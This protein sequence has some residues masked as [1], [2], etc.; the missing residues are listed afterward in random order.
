MGQLSAGIIAQARHADPRP[1]FNLWASLAGIN[2][3]DDMRVPCCSN[4]LLLQV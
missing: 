1:P 2:N 3:L 4:E